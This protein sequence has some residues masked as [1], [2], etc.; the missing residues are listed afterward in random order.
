MLQQWGLA[1]DTPATSAQRAALL[2][3][4]WVPG[5]RNTPEAVAAD[6]AL[7]CCEALKMT[8]PADLAA[9]TLRCN[10][11]LIAAASNALADAAS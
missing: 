6:S 9:V 2:A 11:A 4:L 7:V 5:S 3:Q 8:P 10:A 1:T